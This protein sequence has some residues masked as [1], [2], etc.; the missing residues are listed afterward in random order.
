MWKGPLRDGITQ[1]LLNRFLE[2]PYSFYLY[3]ILGLEDPITQSPLNLWWGDTFHKGLELY[4]PSKDFK[5]SAE[6]MLDYLHERYP[7]APE[8]FDYSTKKMLWVYKLNNFEGDWVTEEIIDEYIDVGP[9]KIRIRGKK[10][11][12]CRNHPQY[13]TVLAEHKAKGY[14]DPSKT[15]EELHVDLQCAL[16]LSTEEDCEWVFYDLIKI[17]EVQKYGP[18]KKHKESDKDYISRLFSGP[19]GSYKGQYP[20]F[21]NEHNWVHQGIHHFPLEAQEQMMDFTIKP[22][23]LRLIEWYDYV[24]QPDFDHEDPKYFS[25]IFYRHP[26]RHFNARMTPSYNCNYHS[27]LIG[28][29]DL[30]DLV[31]VD[32]YFSELEEPT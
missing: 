13:G 7:E 3:A 21:L 22:L 30:S 32:S 9:H 4:I 11:G 6:G 31:P 5:S 26:V 1:S 18:A 15:R 14:I 20:I 17:P 19:C 12:I 16:Y 2:C 23:I 25:S 27:Y 10:D 29:S 8:S 28:E 24:T